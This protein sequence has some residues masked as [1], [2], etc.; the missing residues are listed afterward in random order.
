LRLSQE[1]LASWVGAT[2]EATAK[3]LAMLRSM[4]VIN[5]ARRRVEVLDAARLQALAG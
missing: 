3:A 4:G 2:R 1:E 5:T